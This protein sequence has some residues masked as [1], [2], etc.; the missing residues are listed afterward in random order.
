MSE[1]S[2]TKT[3]GPNSWEVPPRK[4][5]EGTKD[6]PPVTGGATRRSTGPVVSDTGNGMNWR[7]A[8]SDKSPRAAGYA[9]ESTG[10]TSTGLNE[11]RDIRP[12]GSANEK[13]GSTD[14]SVGKERTPRSVLVP[15]ESTRNTRGTSAR[16]TVSPP[17]NWNDTVSVV[18]TERG[19]REEIAIHVGLSRASLKFLV[20]VSFGYPRTSQSGPYKR[21]TSW[22]RRSRL[23]G[24]EKCAAKL[25]D[26]TEAKRVVWF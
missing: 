9:T 18:A 26:N 16:V 21:A 15:G 8:E 24:D 20:P 7:E 17:S 25:R 22:R 1:R 2:T 3:V 23:S 5:G 6:A 11:P 13:S 12:D 10:V 14:T 19:R 4:R